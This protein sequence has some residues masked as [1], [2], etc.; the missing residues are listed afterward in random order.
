MCLLLC[1]IYMSVFIS[2][3]LFLKCHITSDLQSL[4]QSSHWPRFIQT[5]KGKVYWLPI[6]SDQIFPIVCLICT[7]SVYW[8]QYRLVMI[9][10]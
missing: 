5:C 9:C 1:N 7:S 10:L 3:F 8:D 4:I 6:R 2:I